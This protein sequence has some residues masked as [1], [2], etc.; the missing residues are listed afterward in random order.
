MLI[1]IENIFC[2]YR[3]YSTLNKKW[4]RFTIVRVILDL[5][6]HIFMNISNI[7]L[8]Y[9]DIATKEVYLY[10]IFGQILSIYSD[11]V[12]IL[13]AIIRSKS[14]EM[15]LVNLTTLHRQFTGDSTY[16]KTVKWL[17]LLT[18]PLLGIFVTFRTPF[19]ITR[20]ENSTENNGSLIPDIKI[21]RFFILLLTQMLCEIR[22]L[23]DG[24][25]FFCLLIIVKRL[26]KCLNSSINLTKNKLKIIEMQKRSYVSRA[27]N[28]Y[29]RM[30]SK[31]DIKQWTEL[32][33]LFVAISK[34]LC[35]CF[36]D[37]VSYKGYGHK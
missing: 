7:I 34:L 1:F 37:Q 32:Y 22:Y 26:L 18:L 24:F 31:D 10:S 8:I 28:E 36:G 3:N 29:Y 30:L 16:K 19:L 23:L 2:V 25:F 21:I 6:I 14:C 5:A 13:Y 27:R 11:F 20:I 12:I 35:T 9:E 15:L 4:K 33:K 17:R